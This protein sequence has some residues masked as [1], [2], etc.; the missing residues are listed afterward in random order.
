MKLD[1]EH[2]GWTCARCGAI[3]ISADPATRPL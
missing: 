3:A 1:P 2:T